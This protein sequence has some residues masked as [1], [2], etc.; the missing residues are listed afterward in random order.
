VAAMLILQLFFTQAFKMPFSS[1]GVFLFFLYFSKT[2]A[3]TLAI[4]SY[5]Q[6]TIVE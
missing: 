4:S 3:L 1:L 2:K 6:I 5:L